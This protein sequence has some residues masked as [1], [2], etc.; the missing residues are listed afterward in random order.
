MEELA[1][2]HA[3]QAQ[4]RADSVAPTMEQPTVVELTAPT[5]EEPTTTG[6]TSPSGGLHDEGDPSVEEAWDAAATSSGLTEAGT[7]L[8]G[9][10]LSSGAQG[11][12]V[13]NEQAS[14]AAASTVGEALC[15]GYE[16][17]YP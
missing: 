6:P 17:R 3:E 9:D 4:A 16:P 2:P 8:A 1:A 7:E 15:G 12:P 11:P 13:V 10:A 14:S 5:M